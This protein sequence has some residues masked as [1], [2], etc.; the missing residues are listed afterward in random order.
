MPIRLLSD[1]LISQIAAGEVVERPASVIKELIEN[2]VD[3]QAT[4]IHVALDNGGIRAIRVRD[5]GCGIPSHELELAVQRH[6]TSKIAS[7]DDLIKVATHGFRGEALAAIGSVARMSIT[8]KTAD[9]AHAMRI[10]N[11][12]GP[13]AL[14]PASGPNGTHVD[15]E[16]LF[17]QIPARKRF[18]KS[19]A[20]ELNHCKD[21]FNRIAMIQPSIQWLMSHQGKPVIRYPAGSASQR[22]A[23]CL[24]ATETD[25]RVVDVQAGPMRIQ[26]WLVPP[27]QSRAR[28]DDQY[29][30]VNRRP[31]RD[32]VLM[33]AVKAAYQDVL[34]SDRQPAFLVALEIDPELVD[35]NVHPAK[36]E[37]RFRESP[38]VH[39]AVF[40]AIRDALAPSASLRD[41]RDQPPAPSGARP[42]LADTTQPWSPSF[43]NGQTTSLGL[44]SDTTPVRAAFNFS[45][46]EPDLGSLKRTDN[47]GAQG[48]EEHPL[49]FALGQL[50][51][52]YILA[53]NKH[54]LILVDMHAAHERVVYEALKKQF[55][56]TQA[57]ASCQSLLSPVVLS[58]SPL[59]METF[60]LQ[61]SALHQLGFDLDQISEQQ[62]AI[63][64][65]PVMLADSNPIALVRDTLAELGQEGAALEV[66]SQRN[67]LLAQMAC[68]AAVRA[69]R[70]LTIPEMNA[71]LRAME[72][73]DR[74]DQCNHGRPTWLAFSL[75]D[76]DKL[77]LRGQ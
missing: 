46:R 8:S 44:Q 22:I 55:D 70:S 66:E 7:Q 37:V 62:I 36:N 33:H 26:A 29:F 13:W 61:K 58:A 73:T 49:G 28:A 77:F 30:Y 67:E 32:R 9:A 18:L 60:R 72:R 6:A 17:D 15:V 59:E 24:N 31:V 40:R 27:T 69:N 48:N 2:A 50:H 10:D 14:S 57:E 71:L 35:V 21:I 45:A 63:R 16:G 54:G 74:A 65:L 68:H 52:I 51:S 47:W 75:S 64:G 34:H 38:A 42:P 5:D 19:P 43:G 23:Q 1:L 11:H 41:D 3:A 76:L 20:T 56:G 39:Q 53:Q 12:D 4:E 25:L